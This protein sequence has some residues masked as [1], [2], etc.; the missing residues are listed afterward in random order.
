[1]DTSSNYYFY[2]RRNSRDVFVH[3]QSG[4]NEFTTKFRMSHLVSSSVI[5]L[6]RTSD[7]ISETDT[8]QPRY[9]RDIIFEFVALNLNLVESFIGMPEMI[10]EEIF[11]S[12]LV[13]NEARSKHIYLIIE[14]FPNSLRQCTVYNK[15]QL[16]YIFNLNT[17]VLY[18]I[19]RLFINCLDIS[20]N[21]LQTIGSMNNLSILQLD[22]CRLFDDDL[23]ILTSRHRVMGGSLN[24]LKHLSLCCNHGLSGKCMQYLQEIKSLEVLRF[25][26]RQKSSWLGLDKVNLS[27]FVNW[28]WIEIDGYEHELQFSESPS[29][30]NWIKHLLYDLFVDFDE[31]VSNTGAQD[32]T[33]SGDFRSNQTGLKLF[34]GD[35]ESLNYNGEAKIGVN[36]A[37][38]ATMYWFLVK[39]STPV[40]STSTVGTLNENVMKKTPK[41]KRDTDHKPAS[42][43]I[44]NLLK[45][46][47]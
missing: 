46:Y 23:R 4:S 36:K 40:Q 13:T 38:S 3:Q 45:L 15:A 42:D 28:K 31:D 39:Y 34:Y 10:V 8:Y 47:M 6:P 24:C 44:S 29:S 18:Q 25:C 2:E 11:T 21:V 14:A 20:K 17:N 35:V 33:Y 19:E 27:Q 1:M 5:T 9:L 22:N 12:D 37:C 7:I 30:D 26:G 43:N 32:D 41:R 16:L